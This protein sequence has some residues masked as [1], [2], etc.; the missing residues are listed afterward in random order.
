MRSIIGEL[1]KT[2]AKKPGTNGGEV[3]RSQIA[4][5]RFQQKDG[6]LESDC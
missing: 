3:S 5:I 2:I 6:Y 4:D 1:S